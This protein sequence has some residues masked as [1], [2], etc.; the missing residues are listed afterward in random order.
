MC[1]LLGGLWNF[2]K[3]LIVLFEIQAD[4]SPEDVKCLWCDFHIQVTGLPF[5]R[6]TPSMAECISR[7]V[8]VFP[9]MDLDTNRTNPHSFLR[10]RVSRNV[11]KPSKQ[12]ISIKT[13]KDGII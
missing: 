5:N 1:A 10:I 6:M 2:N 3:H 9:S 11:S 13:P 8:G 12:V 7:S 4:E